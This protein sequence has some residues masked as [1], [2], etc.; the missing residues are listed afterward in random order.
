MPRLVLMLVATM[1]ISLTASETAFSAPIFLDYSGFDTRLS[2]LAASAG[3]AAFSGA[4]IDTIKANI[5]SDL[6]TIYSDFDATFTETDPGGVTDIWFGGTTAPGGLGV[7]DGIDFGNMVLDDLSRVFSA[8]FDFIIE[9]GD[10]RATQIDELS[11]ALSGTAAHELGHN[12]GLRHHDAYGDLTYTG[13]TIATGGAQNAFIMAT[14]ST[15]LSETGRETTR[16][17]NTHEKVKLSFAS[18]FNASLPTTLSETADFASTI[19][20]ATAASALTLDP[21]AVVTRSAINILGEITTSGDSDIF[22]LD[23]TSGTTLTA[24]V[25]NDFSGVFPPGFANGNTELR[26]YDPTGTLV[27]SNTVSAY[28]GNTFGAG[29]FGDG[30][31]PALF[32]V[33][34]TATGNWFVEVV[35]E[36]GATGDYQLLL[37]ADTVTS[38]TVVPEPSSFALLGVGLMSA[39]AWRRRRQRKDQNEKQNAV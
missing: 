25:N 38:S 16:T 37:H 11:A 28:S 12:L 34:I 18:G 26:I 14:G 9:A 33:P 22:R 2:E 6:E 7:A 36:G 21:L 3:I 27:A 32:N 10:A 20:A 24:D 1:A 39:G 30:F 13:G 31:D 35:G 23:L 5:K 29:G 15:G 4:E 19:A 17:F 8:N